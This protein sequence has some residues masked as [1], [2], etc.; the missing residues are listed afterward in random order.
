M[1][2]LCAMLVYA[3]TLLLTI[4]LSSVKLYKGSSKVNY[5]PQLTNSKYV[6]SN[7]QKMLHIL[8]VSYFQI[9]FKYL[10]LVI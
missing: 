9:H 2:V 1:L 10:I 8:I 4:R 7:L 6:Q 3:R 5:L